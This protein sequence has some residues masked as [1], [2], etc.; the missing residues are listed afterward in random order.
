M[1]KTSVS[2]RGESQTPTI[3]PPKCFLPG[4]F[5]LMHIQIYTHFSNKIKV[6]IECPLFATQHVTR[7]FSR[8]KMPKYEFDKLSTVMVWMCHISLKCVPIA[9]YLGCFQVF[10][11]TKASSINI[12]VHKSLFHH[13]SKFLETELPE[14]RVQHL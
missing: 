1:E 3:P 14:Q 10:T 8:P 7:A 9:R 12:L 11:I 4:L 13:V 2:G 6:I 5:L